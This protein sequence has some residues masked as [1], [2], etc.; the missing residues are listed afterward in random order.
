MFLFSKI[1]LTKCLGKKQR[2]H[3]GKK[4]RLQNDRILLDNKYVSTPGELQAQG[5][6]EEK[7]D[8]EKQEQE[9]K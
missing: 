1:Y 3:R 5:E 4:R 7:E 6:K 9:Q 8:A 2:I